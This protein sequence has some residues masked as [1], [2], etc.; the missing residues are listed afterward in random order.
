MPCP[1]LGAWTALHRVRLPALQP[2]LV[3]HGGVHTAPRPASTEHERD[4]LAYASQPDGIEAGGGRGDVR[5]QDDVV[6]LE[7]RIRWDRGLLFE[8]IEPGARDPALLQR[9]DERRL[10]DG[11]TTP[12][13]DKER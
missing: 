9:L 12:R 10:V 13:V 4:L 6:H 5:R 11:G 7:E 3:E 1:G 8:H 2:A